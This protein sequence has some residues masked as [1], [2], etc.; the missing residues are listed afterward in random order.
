MPPKTEHPWIRPDY[1]PP[2]TF[3]RL[4]DLDEPP[5]L[6]LTALALDHKRLVWG[7]IQ[8]QAPALA[9]VL[10]DPGLRELAAAFD[11]ELFVFLP[12]VPGGVDGL[13]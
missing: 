2:G 5:M 4:A 12:D 11:A 1:P 9:A 7:R 8:A 13:D 10:A 3:R 6:N